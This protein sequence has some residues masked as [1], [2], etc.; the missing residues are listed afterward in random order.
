MG[1]ISR[2]SPSPAARILP[3]RDGDCQRSG[4]KHKGIHQEAKLGPRK[5]PGLLQRWAE[6]QAY[7]APRAGADTH[8]SA[9]SRCAGVA[10]QEGLISPRNSSPFPGPGAEV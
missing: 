1:L 8:Q 7:S 10:R 3:G 6:A 4:R 2:H 5:T 9:S